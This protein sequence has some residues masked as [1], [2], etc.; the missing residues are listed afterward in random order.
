MSLIRKHIDE[1]KFSRVYLLF[2]EEGYLISQYRDMLISCLVAPDDNMNIS[3]YTSDTFD[4]N[5]IASDIV[6]LPFL[7]EYRVVLV[8]DSGLFDRSDE[9]LL[10]SISQMSDMNILIFCEK[11]V[12]KRKK[13]FTSLSKM[14]TASV[15]EF[16]TPDMNTLIKWVTSLVSGDG[17]RIRATVPEKLIDTVGTDMFT[18][19]NEAS[20]LH[21]YCIERGE[22]TDQDIDMICSN[23]VEDKVFEMCEA[24][25]NRN[26]QKAISLYTDLCT[27][28]T[29]PMSIIY[30]IT[31]QYTQLVQV[32]EMINEGRNSSEIASHLKI[33]DFVVRKYTS[34][35]KSYSHPALL[36][37]L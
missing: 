35:C 34:I 30:L 21:D 19:K 6:T 18:L 27:L 29:K 8:E 31:R 32:S 37:M 25:S 28:R 15:L 3:S 11:K 14:D 20:K 24:I 9:T 36:K 13:L 10:K 22:V 33:R 7:A 12:D 5:S 23:P 17:L 4:I 2:G 1:H 26:S 16:D